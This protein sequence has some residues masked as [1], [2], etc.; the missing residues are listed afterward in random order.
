[1]KYKCTILMSVTGFQTHAWPSV[2]H[3]H[4]SGGHTGEWQVVVLEPGV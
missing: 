3:L 1:M 4:G 2:S